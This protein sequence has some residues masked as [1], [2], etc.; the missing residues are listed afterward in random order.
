[1]T[2]QTPL[3]EQRLWAIDHPYY[4]A[5]GNFFKNGQHTVFA[6]WQEFADETLFV[7]GDRDLN[8][9]FRWDWRKP[10]FHDWDGDEYLLLFFVLQRKSFNCSQQVTVTEADEPAVRA[11]LE[12]CARTMRAT[13]ESILDAPPATSV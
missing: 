11:F 3:T 5:E 10:G 4:C 2:D 9:L 13:W 8:L 7:T 12:D 1:M 6:S